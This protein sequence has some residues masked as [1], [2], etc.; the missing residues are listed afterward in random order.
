MEHGSGHAFRILQPRKTPAHRRKP[1]GLERPLTMSKSWG[2]QRTPS[3]RTEPTN[4]LEL[5][6]IYLGLRHFEHNLRDQEVQISCNNTVALYYLNKQGGTRNERLLSIARHIL[7]WAAF[8]GVTLRARHIPGKLNTIADGLS[9]SNQLL[10]TEWSLC[11][12]VLERIWQK[13]HRPHVDL[14]AT[15]YASP[16]PDLQ[17]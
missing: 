13:G 7:D 8:W 10:T 15:R 17:A 9:R 11:P 1:P 5:Q 3:L 4:T 14:F 6:A 2:E 16:W 12:G